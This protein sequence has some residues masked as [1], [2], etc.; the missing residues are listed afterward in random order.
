TVLGLPFSRD[1]KAL[2]RTMEV[3]LLFALWGWFLLT[4]IFAYYPADAWGQFSKVSKI[5]VGIF[6]SLILLQEERK[7]RALVW[8]IA[9][10]IGF[11]GCNGGICAIM[12]GGHNQVVGPLDSFVTGNPEIGLALNMTIPLL[13]YLRRQEPRW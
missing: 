5:L 3:Y 6:L 11:Y 2:P 13:F 9:M 12:P 8:V 10:S 4:T 7:F 1:V